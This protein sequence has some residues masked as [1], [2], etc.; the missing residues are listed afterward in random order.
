[1]NSETQAIHPAHPAS[2]FGYC[3]MSMMTEMSIMAH[4]VLTE[5]VCFIIV[6]DCRRTARV[7][8]IEYYLLSII[9]YWRDC[10]AYCTSMLDLC[11]LTIDPGPAVR[12]VCKFSCQ[13]YYQTCTH[14]PSPYTLGYTHSP[15]TVSPA[16]PIEPILHFG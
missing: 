5:I 2:H 13:P 6:W 16:R 10:Q 1:M 14:A 8:F 11:A 12:S 4:M 9:Y 7:L 3:D 15:T